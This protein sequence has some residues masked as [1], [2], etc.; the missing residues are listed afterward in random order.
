MHEDERRHKRSIIALDW[1]PR[2][3]RIEEAMAHHQAPALAPRARYRL[4]CRLQCLHETASI[5]L[6]MESEATAK[7]IAKAV[8]GIHGSVGRI[9]G[10]ARENPRGSKAMHVLGQAADRWVAKQ[11]R[12]LVEGFV[13]LPVRHG[14]AVDWRGWLLIQL[15]I[16]AAPLVL[17]ILRD[18]EIGKSALEEMSW[19]S[20][21]PS[22]IGMR[23]PRLFEL[24]YPR[25]GTSG[26]WIGDRIEGPKFTFVIEAAREIGLGEYSAGSV[27]TTIQRQA[28]RSARQ[29]GDTN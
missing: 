20:T 26:R 24:T 7:Q 17:E 8:R 5:G 13:D 11:P 27:R 9:A 6:A 18:S 4:A 29:Q 12:K 14:D 10:F 19:S 25:M 15:W 22:L 28:K 2:V 21:S 16:E 23:L 3:A 1:C